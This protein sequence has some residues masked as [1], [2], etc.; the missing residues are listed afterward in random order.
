M[1]NFKTVTAALALGLAVTAAATPAPAAQRIH[2]P[3][4]AA[5]AQAIPGDSGDGV[6]SHR[7]AAIRACNEQGDKYLQYVWGNVSS[8]VYRACMAEHGEA[9]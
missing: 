3:G 6:S 8:D 7:A 5:R 9:E 1:I 4:Y 2:H